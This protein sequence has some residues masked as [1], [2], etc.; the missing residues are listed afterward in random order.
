[1]IRRI[2]SVAE[3]ETAARQLVPDIFGGK[4]LAL[5]EGYGLSYPFAR[6]FA[7]ERALICDYYGAAVLWGEADE[8]CAEF[9]AAAGFGE[10]LMSRENYEKAFLGQPAAIDPVMSRSGGGESADRAALRTDTPYEQVFDILKDGFEIRFEDWYPDACH[11]V[12]HGISAVYTL[13]ESALQRMFTQKGITL[14]SLVAVKK[15]RRGEGLGKRLV[16]AAAADCPESRI[17]IICEPQLCGFYKSCGFVPDGEAAA[18][19]FNNRKE[20]QT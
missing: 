18:V 10:L 17:Y 16:C 5:A 4:I 6:F 19:Y 1:M 13:G 9:A 2:S 3:L 14:F 15:E 7:A 8:E 12:R 11:M 20:I